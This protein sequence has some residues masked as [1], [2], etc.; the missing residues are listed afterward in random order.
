MSDIAKASLTALLV[1]IAFL[2]FVGVIGLVTGEI[3]LD[4]SGVVVVISP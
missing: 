2:I 3:D 4:F 1:G